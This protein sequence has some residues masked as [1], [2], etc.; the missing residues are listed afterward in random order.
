MAAVS[1]RPS[2]VKTEFVL[3]AVAQGNM[4]LDPERAESPRFSGRCV[5]ALAADANVLEKSGGVY[6]V[7][8]LAAEYGFV[9]PDREAS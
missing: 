2:A 7:K 5:A 8:E 3:D 6:S 1:L 9:D 4:Q